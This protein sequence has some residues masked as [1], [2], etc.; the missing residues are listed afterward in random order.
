MKLIWG[1]RL[2]GKHVLRWLSRYGSGPVPAT[3][4]GCVVVLALGEYVA[5]GF[6]SM[7]QLAS[8]L[9]VAAILAFAAAGQVFVIISGRE[10]ID[11][12]IGSVMSLGAL[13]AGN[14]MDGQASMILPAACFAILAGLAIGLFNGFGVT[15]L[16]I[17]PLVMTLGTA[18]VVTGLLVVLTQGVPSGSAAPELIRFISRADFWGLPGIVFLWAGLIVA[19]HLFQTRSR[20]GL[21]LY[22]IGANDRAAHLSGISVRF[23]RMM[24][25]ALSGSFA[26]LAGFILVGFTGSVFIGAGEQYI[27]PSVIAAV[28]GGISLAGGSGLYVGA[29]VGATFLTLLTAMLTSM[30][31]SLADRQIVYGLVLIL[32]MAVYS[33]QH[34]GSR[35]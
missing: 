32:F 4:L 34:A 35:L 30:S 31:L 29:A 9:S 1:K 27:L 26:G 20:F 33:R 10:G 22:A 14:M 3:L 28:I 6:A 11:L 24:A 21:A 12:S 5:P 16:K 7:S 2:W 19:L 15:L 17:A 25:Y 13:I 23:T 8:Q 18:G